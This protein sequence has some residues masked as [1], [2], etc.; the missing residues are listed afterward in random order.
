MDNATKLG[1][2]RTGAQ[3]SP[4]LTSTMQS[5]ADEQ[6]PQG[7]G[8]TAKAD[9]NGIAAVRANYVLEA[10]RVGS[11][12]M[13][14]TVTNAFTTAVSKLMGKKPEVLID[15]LGERLAFERTGVRLYQALIDKA[16]ALGGRVAMPFT[17][18][19]L[20]HIQQEELEHMHIVAS[21]LEVLGADPTAQTPSADVAGV[22]SSG[23]IHTL[24]DPRTTIPHCLEAILT[25]E[26][27]DDASWELLISLSEQAGQ[28]DLLPDF[29][30]ALQHEAEHVERVKGWLSAA[31]VGE[32]KRD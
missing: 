20:K 2:N 14:A 21:A 11:V 24:T 32:L 31:V 29:E 18:A 13:P 4:L 15:K 12:P 22:T 7:G 28:D 23:V 9:A 26:L 8:G 27:I 1:F 16:E 5:F 6:S 17:V 10:D 30:R 19:D 25:A 3:T